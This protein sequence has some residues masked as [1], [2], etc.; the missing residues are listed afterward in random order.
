M[1]LVSLTFHG[2]SN[3]IFKNAL[4]IKFFSFSSSNIILHLELKA[5]D[6]N[7][8]FLYFIVDR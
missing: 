5:F 8:E 4:S 1:H 7:L 2:K 3:E 6:D